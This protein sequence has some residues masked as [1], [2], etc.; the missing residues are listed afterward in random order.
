MISALQEHARKIPLPTDASMVEMT[1]NFLE[2][3]HLIFEKG[4]LSHMRISPKYQRVLENIK[5]G[6]SFFK[7]WF[8][9]HQNTGEKPVVNLLNVS[10]GILLS[11]CNKCLA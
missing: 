11:D 10:H 3:C 2:A 7:D 5:E 1:S 6:F 8:I 4:L 9:C